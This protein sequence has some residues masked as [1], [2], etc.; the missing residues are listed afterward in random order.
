MTAGLVGVTTLPNA[1]SAR[2]H[3]EPNSPHIIVARFVETDPEEFSITSANNWIRLR[4]LLSQME[5]DQG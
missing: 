2:G 5:R 1:D 3:F 4:W